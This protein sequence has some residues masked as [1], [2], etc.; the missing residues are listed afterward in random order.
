MNNRAGLGIKLRKRPSDY[1]FREQFGEL[2]KM[3]IITV[4]DYLIYCARIGSWNWEQS[5]LAGIIQ[6]NFAENVSTLK[7]CR[8]IEPVLLFAQKVH[9]S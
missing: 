2:F 9:C 6:E 8:K 7:L 1:G 5:K 3:S 4:L